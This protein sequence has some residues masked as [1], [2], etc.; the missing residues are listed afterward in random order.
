MKTMAQAN[1]YLNEIF[2]PTYWSKRNVVQA[3]E[4]H[5]EYRTLEQI[6]CIKKAR[7]LAADHTFSFAGTFYAITS[8]LE[9][10]LKGKHIEIR[11]YANPSAPMGVYFEDTKLEWKK[12]NVK[13]TESSIEDTYEEY[14]GR[15]E[16][17]LNPKKNRDTITTKRLI[18]E[19]RKNIKRDIYDEKLSGHL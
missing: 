13:G 8:K 17:W 1:E 18:A 2:L 5:S 4:S 16:A 9:R 7:T 12:V 11:F 19:R 15:M 6:F 14:V 10:S 3:R